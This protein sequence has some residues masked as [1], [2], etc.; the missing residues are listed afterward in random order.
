MDGTLGPHAALSDAF[1]M[2]GNRADIFFF[3]GLYKKES[4]QFANP[5]LWNSRTDQERRQKKSLGYDIVA[6]GGVHV[7]PTMSN[8]CW[9]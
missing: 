8:Y 6:P 5:A 9:R 1:L 3:S 7:Q 2:N 4:K